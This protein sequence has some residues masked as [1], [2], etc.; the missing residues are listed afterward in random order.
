MVSLV[1][2]AEIAHGDAVLDQL[3]A[4][5]AVRRAEEAFVFQPE[6]ELKGHHHGGG[7]TTHAQALQCLHYRLTVGRIEH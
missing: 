3:P 7:E 5:L 6:I 2:H 1:Q 4:E